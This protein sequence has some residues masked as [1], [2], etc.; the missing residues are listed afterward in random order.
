M[1]KN[2]SA[3]QP[4]YHVTL[5][6]RRTRAPLGSFQLDADEYTL[7]ERRSQSLGLTVEEF[8]AQA[9]QCEVNICPLD[10]SF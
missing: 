2:T 10:L 3:T 6:A 9:M 1:L 4:R 5:T 7:Y 8:I